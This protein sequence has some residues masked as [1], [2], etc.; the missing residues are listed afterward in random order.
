MAQP[1][2]PARTHELEE[3]SGDTPTLSSS[4]PADRRQDLGVATMSLISGRAGWWK[5]PCPDL[6]RAPGERSPGATLLPV[7]VSRTHRSRIR[8]A[9]VVRRAH[10]YVNGL[11]FCAIRAYRTAWRRKQLQGSQN[12][13]PAPK[14]GARSS[15]CACRPTCSGPS[16]RRRLGSRRHVKASLSHEARRCGY[17]FGAGLPLRP[18][19][20]ARRQVQVHRPNGTSVTTLAR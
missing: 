16:T 11:T 13:S 7:G 5:S 6:A 9:W 20:R 10:A 3:V 18:S 19:R 12:R 2:E 8:Q 17:L 4:T 1:S 14:R 15:R